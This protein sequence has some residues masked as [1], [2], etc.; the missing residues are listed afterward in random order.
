MYRILAFCKRNQKKLLS[1]GCFFAAC[2]LVAL[3]MIISLSA[4]VCVKTEQRILTLGELQRSE[5]KWDCILVLGC[6]VYDDGRMSDMLSDRVKTGLSLYH[7]GL[8]GTLVMS[9]DRQPSGEYDEV[10]AMQAAAILDGVS[11]ENILI[12]PFGYSTFESVFNLSQEYE[13]KRVLIVTQQYHLYRALYIAE[14]LGIDAYGVS[15]DLQTYRG[16]WSRELREALAR[17]KD[18]WYVQKFCANE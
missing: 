17:I 10:G 18:V 11:E 13:G 5:S 6:R 1:I 8:S 15:A 2:L 4:A 14:R 7:M 16:Q 3:V 9:G 12:D